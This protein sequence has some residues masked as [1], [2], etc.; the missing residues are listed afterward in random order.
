[1][2]N[3]MPV[4]CGTPCVG[5]FLFDK[6]EL[7][8]RWSQHL[9]DR[10]NFAEHKRARAAGAMAALQWS[11]GNITSAELATILAVPEPNE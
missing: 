1:M 3:R 10:A 4:C 2:N 9:A 7:I 8:E 5:T 6:K 11:I